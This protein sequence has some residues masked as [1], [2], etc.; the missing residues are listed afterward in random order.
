MSF[1]RFVFLLTVALLL[2]G[3]GVAQ[4]ERMDVSASLSKKDVKPEEI[5]YVKINMNV[6]EGFHTY[7]VKQKDPNASAFSTS[8]RVKAASESRVEKAGDVKEPDG[9]DKLEAALNATIT[10]F[11]GLVD[12]EVP[13]KVKKGTPPGKAK[14]T[15]SLVTQVCDDQGCLPFNKNYDF[16]IT[17]QGDGKPPEQ[18][19][20]KPPQVEKDKQIGE[21]KGDPQPVSPNADKAPTDPDAV[22]EETLLSFILTGVGF[23]FITLL[24]PCVFPMIPITVSFFLKKNKKGSE[25]IMNALIYTITIILSLSV[26]AYLLVSFFQQLTQM[27]ITNV[28]LGA[29]F[30]YF[31][32]SLFGAYEITLP[33]FL[34][35]WTS[36]GESKGGYIGTIFMAMTFTLISFSCVAPFMGAF[37]GATA[38]A[39]PVLWNILGAL[40]FSIAFASPFFV[41]ALFPSWLKALPKSGSW[42]NTLKVVMAFLEVAAAIKFFRTA[43]VLWKR[44]EP[45][46]LT[47]DFAIG[48]YIAM[49]ILCCVYLLGMYKLP[50]D[51]HDD[52]QGKIGVFRLM[53][54]LLF[55]SL[56]IYLFPAMFRDPNGDKL[57]PAGVV[58]SWIDAFLLPSGDTK[59]LKLSF[60][61]GGSGS[62][63]GGKA[64]E[65]Q[66]WFAFLP[67]ALADAKTRKQRIFIDFTGVS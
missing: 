57:R 50:H 14:F 1:M 8:F 45:V 51:D 59:P 26:F 23:G 19:K 52:N 17:V 25:A 63:S 15:L 3:V 44:G 29:L 42:M 28:A 31:A 24:T 6:K 47:Y 5:F 16:E 39:R 9:K 62:G 18:N 43:E 46:Y 67:E 65:K 2:P 35:R 56:G 20:E 55:L 49:C 58:F 36:A 61:G 48:L 38:K 54:S 37:A 53:W 12:L 21:A 11:E 34:T 33:G 10:I 13:V 41:L 22:P 7:A 30:L 32:F 40:S 64:E 66:R 4:D 60:R 27:S